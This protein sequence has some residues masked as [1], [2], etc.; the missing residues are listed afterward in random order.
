[1]VPLCYHNGVMAN[2]TIKKLP[3]PVYKRL[4]KHAQLQGRSLN[5]QV[6]HMLQ[7]DLD[8]Y[9]RFEKMRESNEELERLVASM[10]PMEDSTP[11]IREDRERD[12]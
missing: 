6:I 12:T 3:D 10:P 9:A 11:L 8:D 4:K 2:L 1:M 7:S 5:A